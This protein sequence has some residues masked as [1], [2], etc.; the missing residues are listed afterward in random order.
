MFDL[1]SS[2]VYF[3]VSRIL[4]KLLIA[5]AET[6]STEVRQASSVPD[7]LVPSGWPQ[8]YLGNSMQTW[9]IEAGSETYACI[10]IFY[11]KTEECCDGLTVS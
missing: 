11:L 9:V 4:M 10:T 7:T 1:F 5:Q 3:H 2:N 8:P 6:V